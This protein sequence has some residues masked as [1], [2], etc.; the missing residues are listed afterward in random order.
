MGDAFSNPQLGEWLAARKVGRLRLVGLDGCFCLQSTAHGALN[1]GYAVEI[2]EDAV[3][4]SFP[5]KWPKCKKE[6]SER[7]AA[8]LAKE[9]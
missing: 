8:V 4:T 5:A 2:V 6:L 1:R 9:N 3:L 7:G